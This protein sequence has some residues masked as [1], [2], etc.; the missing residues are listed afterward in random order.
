MEPELVCCFG[1][2]NGEFPRNSMHIK[3]VITSS[4]P[5]GSNSDYKSEHFRII[6]KPEFVYCLRKNGHGLLKS[7]PKNYDVPS[8]LHWVKSICSLQPLHTC[9]LSNSSEKISTSFPQLAHLH[10]KDFKVLKF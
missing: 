6:A 5:S 8:S 4:S 9:V 10:I 7:A 2:K 3:T 1:L